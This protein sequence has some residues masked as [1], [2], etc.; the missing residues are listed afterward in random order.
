MKQV[1]RIEKEIERVRQELSTKTVEGVA[2]GG[3]VRVVAR[4]DR[5]LLSV[6]IQPAAV[7]PA[8]VAFLED[9]VLA[10]ANQ[11]LV[12]AKE[13]SEKDM[14]AVTRGFNLPGLM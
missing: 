9:L 3:A 7:N 14:S 5:S 4:G 11:A 13:L 6:H 10:A 2:G 12:A 8:D 1:A